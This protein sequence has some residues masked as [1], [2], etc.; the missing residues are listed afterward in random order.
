MTEAD[1]KGPLYRHFLRVMNRARSGSVTRKAR[2]K[3]QAG[4]LPSSTQRRIWR[5]EKPVISATCCSFSSFG[6]D[7][8]A[9][10]TICRPTPVTFGPH[11]AVRCG[12][13][14]YARQVRYTALRLSGSALQ[15]SSRTRR[16]HGSV[17]L[18]RTLDIGARG[19]DGGAQVVDFDLT[20]RDQFPDRSLMKRKIAATSSIRRNSSQSALAG[21]AGCPATLSIG[22]PSAPRRTGS[23]RSMRP[24]PRPSTPS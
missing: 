8:V 18:T 3:R 12:Y 9:D 19:P 6:S 17:T 11:K 21:V 7:G 13:R 22:A 4:R 24:A 14:R 20:L 23:R 16:L 5:M 2:P 1:C 10:E 15:P